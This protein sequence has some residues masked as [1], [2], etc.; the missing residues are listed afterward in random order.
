MKFKAILLISTVFLL[1]CNSGTD[2]EKSSGEN[3]EGTISKT[4]QTPAF[5]D[6]DTMPVNNMELSRQAIDG[7]EHLEQQTPQGTFNP[8]EDLIRR[9]LDFYRDNEYS[10]ALEELNKAIQDDPEHPRAYYYR[11]QIY[12]DL[13][14]FKEA[15][16]DFLKVASMV[17]DDHRV[18]NFLGA[19]QTHEG[20]NVSAVKSYD[21]AIALDP[22]NSL[23]YFN[24]GSSLGQLNRLEEAITDF[25]MAVELGM[26]TSGIFN[27]R[28][29]ARYMLGDYEGA[30]ADFTRSMELDPESM[31]PYANRGIAY[32]Y[33]RDTLRACADWQ[34]AL[35]MGHP[36]VGE[37]L[38]RFCK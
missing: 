32:L 31:A 4:I 13:D 27:N 38:E 11:G 26:N 12:T 25:N 21:K 34:R 22:Q 37:Y 29:N 33:M 16:E 18:W 30:I 20:D 7:M 15:K 23:Y 36:L 9:A 10:A 3:N 24:R 14:N 28:A 1:S 5:D 8:Y 35:Q 17:E 6:Q 19:A 2:K